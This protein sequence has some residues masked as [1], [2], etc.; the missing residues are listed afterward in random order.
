MD[1]EE[2]DRSVQIWRNFVN[3]WK[4]WYK[5]TGKNLSKMDITTTEFTVMRHLIQGGPQSM[6]TL[7]NLINVTPGWIT[8]IID[9]MEGNGL[10]LR[11]RQEGDR[12]I[13]NIMITDHGREIFAKAKDLH[14]EFVRR[15]LKE[16]DEK[17]MDDLLNLLK[18]MKTS[19]CDTVHE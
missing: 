1:E 9:K 10:V 19:I 18:K 14:Y 17:E 11:N 8:G 12:R 15:S 7:A 5:E 13:I 6:N 3:I 4:I 2:V 16:L